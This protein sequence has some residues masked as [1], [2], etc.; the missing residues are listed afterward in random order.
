[1]TDPFRNTAHNISGP[2]RDYIPITPSDS[3]ALGYVAMSLYCQGAGSVVVTTYAGAVRTIVVP[4]FGWIICG[5]SKVHATGTT[6]TGIHALV[7]G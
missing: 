3:N 4:A 6:A 7:G 5:V 1:M 2:A